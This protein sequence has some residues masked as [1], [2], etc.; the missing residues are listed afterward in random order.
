MHVWKLRIKGNTFRSNG[1]LSSSTSAHGCEMLKWKIM[2]STRRKE[3]LEVY[4]HICTYTIWIRQLLIIFNA[5]LPFHYAKFLS[6]N[7]K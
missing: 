3:G 6:G 1:V 2:E 5:F 7:E 4:L